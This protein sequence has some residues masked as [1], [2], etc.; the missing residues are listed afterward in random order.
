MSLHNVRIDP[1]CAIGDHFHAGMVEVHD[2][3]AGAGNCTLA[4]TAIPYN[5]GV[6]GIMPADQ[7]HRVEA[8]DKGL[9]LLATFSPPL[10]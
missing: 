6:I 5:P 2:V 1:G 9:L 7:V 3:L 10:V 4:G 8:G